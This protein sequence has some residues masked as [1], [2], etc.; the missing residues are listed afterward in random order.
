M[1]R[2][3]SAF[4]V[5]LVSFPTLTN[6]A[7]WVAARHFVLFRQQWSFPLLQLWIE[8]VFYLLAL[9]FGLGTF[10][11]DVNGVD[12]PSF[13]VPG[14]ISLTAFFVAFGEAAN[15]V[16]SRLRSQEFYKV[17]LLTHVQPRDL[18]W[19]EVI[20]ACCKGIAAT[21]MFLVTCLF[22]GFLSGVSMIGAQ[23]FL[24]FVSLVGSTLGVFVGTQHK[25]VR[26]RVLVRALFST[27]GVLFAGAYFPMEAFSVVIEKLSYVFPTR[28]VVEVYRHLLAGRFPPECFISLAVLFVLFVLGSNLALHLFER[29]LIR[30]DQELD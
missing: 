3:G 10:V 4:L 28:H 8:P 14:L 21:Q 18:M 29:N 13:L 24:C 19:G 1:I 27:P 5:D 16:S 15:A 26:F 25:K 30:L 12:Y 23:V 20:W 2:S 11:S 9:G 22:V 6:R 17:A 7:F